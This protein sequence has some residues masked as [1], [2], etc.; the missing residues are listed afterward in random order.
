MRQLPDT[1]KPGKLLTVDAEVYRKSK[2]KLRQNLMASEN[3]PLRKNLDN[4]PVFVWALFIL[5]LLIFFKTNYPL[6]YRLLNKSW[7]SSISLNEFFSTQTSV[8]KN[9][10]LLTWLIISQC[11]SLAVYIVIEV[12]RSS[13][14][15]NVIQLMLLISGIIIL[16]F[17]ANQWLKSV[18][19]YSFYQPGLSQ[20]YAV[21]FRIHAYVA[22]LIL[23]PILLLAYYYNAPQM[24]IFST[25]LLVSCVIL[26]YVISI[27]KFIFSG[28]IL[29][30]QS[31]FILFL[32]LCAFEILPLLVL[33]KSVTNLLE[34]D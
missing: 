18:F 15:L 20:D 3:P 16:V 12:D 14:Q 7:Y 30:N 26:I 28:R 29:G 23:L 1:M 17:M 33:V 13:F 10:K 19:A 25:V 24:R 32:Y 34:Y 6:Q 4:W 9:S 21:I 8:F 27:F 22:S 2:D 11:L 31:N 5:L